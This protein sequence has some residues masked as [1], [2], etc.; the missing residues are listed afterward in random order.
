M[1]DPLEELRPTLPLVGRLQLRLQAHIAPIPVRN[2]PRRQRAGAKVEQLPRLIDG[3]EAR[4]RSRVHGGHRTIHRAIR[5]L[6]S[7]AVKTVNLLTGRTGHHPAE[8]VRIFPQLEQLPADVDVVRGGDARLSEGV[9]IVFTSSPD[10]ADVII[11][12]GGA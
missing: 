8:Q 7:A 3:S 2:L 5:A 12:G 4:S 6:D 11:R 10:A 9:E 1:L